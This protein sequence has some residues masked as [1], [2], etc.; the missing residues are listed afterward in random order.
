MTAKLTGAQTQTVDVRLL[1]AAD[2]DPALLV[3]QLVHA[4]KGAGAPLGAAL[5]YEPD[6][7][8]HPNDTELYVLNV[9]TRHVIT[10]GDVDWD[11]EAR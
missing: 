5:T 11:G 10:R 9:Q 7:L 2:V 3:A 4:T 6:D 8:A 1:V